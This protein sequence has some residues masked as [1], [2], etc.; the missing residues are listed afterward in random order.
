MSLISKKDLVAR[1]RRG[2]ETRAKLLANNIAESIATQI[3]AT[4][5]KREWTQSRLATEAGMGQNNLS[6]LENPDYGKHTVSSLKRIADALDVALVVRFVPFS[7][8][9]DW[10]SGTPHLDEGISP[11]ALAVPSFEDEEEV[12]QY[13]AESTYFEVRVTPEVEVDDTITTPHT[14]PPPKMVVVN[15]GYD[16]EREVA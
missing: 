1:L 3:V 5:D 7:Q 12:G 13:E 8:F 9:I 2:K 15:L 11:V 10:L 14:P 16:P 4:R 6:R